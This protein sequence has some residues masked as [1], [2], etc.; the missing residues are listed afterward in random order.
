MLNGGKNSDLEKLE[1]E[2]YVLIMV[3]ASTLVW[4]A[5]EDRFRWLSFLHVCKTSVAPASGKFMDHI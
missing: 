2:F 1:R 3:F 4:L 5:E